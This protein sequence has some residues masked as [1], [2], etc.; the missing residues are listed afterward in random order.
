MVHVAVQEMITLLA[1][2]IYPAHVM[3]ILHSVLPCVCWRFC[4][5]R[6]DTTRDLT[7][8]VPPPFA[9]FVSAMVTQ[10]ARTQIWPVYPQLPLTYRLECREV[11]ENVFFEARFRCWLYRHDLFRS[12]ALETSICGR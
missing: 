7:V 10:D 2:D 9:A 1:E 11:A 6:S 8:E 3:V 4:P 12:L 5:V